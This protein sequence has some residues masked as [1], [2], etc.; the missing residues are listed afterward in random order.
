MAELFAGLEGRI[1]VNAFAYAGHGEIRERV[2]GTVD[3]APTPAELDETRALVRQAMHE[4]AFGLST[5]LF[6]V[7]G[8]YAATEEVIELARVA[9]E[10]DGI[11]DTRQPSEGTVHVLVNGRFAVRDGDATGA[12]AGRPIRRP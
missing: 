8:Y 9:A 12:L 3:R 11:Y 7:P 4:G 5:G 1:G 2:I 6:Y 10:F